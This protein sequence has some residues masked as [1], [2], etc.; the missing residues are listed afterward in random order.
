M[1]SDLPGRAKN[2]L[3]AAWKFCLSVRKRD[4]ELV[5]YPV[6]VSEQEIN[7]S[8]T[9]TRL[10]Q[11]RYAARIT[12]WWLTGTG[13]TEQQARQALEGNFANAKTASINSG[14]PLPRP[15]T[16]VPIQFASQE[17]VKRHSALADDFIHRVLKLDWAW[18]SDESSL[19]DFHHND[20]NDM[21][22]AKIKEVYGI[23][24]SDIKSAKLSEILDRIAAVHE[25]A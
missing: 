17:Q 3:R 25:S 20:T 12:N 5:D 6:V 10:K 7:S 23:D 19:W 2:Q 15:G 21:L 8:L 9:G 4:W 18:I 22:I 13:D 24:V 16:R 11:H 1:I 14:K